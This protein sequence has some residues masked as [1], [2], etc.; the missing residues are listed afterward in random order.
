MV[1]APATA[2]LLAKAAHGLADDLLT[3]TL[4]TARCPVRVRARDAHRD[5]A[6]PGHPGQRRDPARARRR[7]C[8]SPAVGPAHRRRHRPGPAARA[9]ARSSPAC[10]AAA[11]RAARRARDLAGRRVVVSAGGTRE[12]STRCA[13][14]ATA[15]RAGRATRSPR[16][17]PPAAPRSTLVAANVELPDPAG[18][19]VVRVVSRRRAARRGAGRRRRRRRRRDGRR[20]RRLPPGDGRGSQ[21]QE[22]RAGEPDADRAGPQPRHPGRAGRGRAA[23][24]A[25]QVVVGLRGRDR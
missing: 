19:K 13:S 11:R 23:A 5:V 18:V 17:P 1:V 7:S 9:R 20:G 15:P 2:D 12:P 21:D 24:P 16:P 14:S 3:N 22:G 8:S 10:A 25:G 4:L 6:A